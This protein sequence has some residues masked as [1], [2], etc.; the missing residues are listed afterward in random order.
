MILQF[1]K[2]AAKSCIK[3]W[4]DRNKPGS[5]GRYQVDNN[6]FQIANC[7]SS[8]SISAWA[9]NNWLGQRKLMSGKFNCE[10][11]RTEMIGRV[12]RRDRRHHGESKRG[13]SPLS[14][15][16]PISGESPTTQIRFAM[17]FKFWTVQTNKI[18]Q[19]LIIQMQIVSAL[20]LWSP[21][22]SSFNPTPKV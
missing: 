13:P 20:I 2:E 15:I 10:G 9:Q 21:M 3:R 19:G 18:N 8:M 14:R 4:G 5:A 17:H 11:N 1:G 22:K 7:I 12:A 16:I 6:H